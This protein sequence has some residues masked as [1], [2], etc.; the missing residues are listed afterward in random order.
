VSGRS[1]G[2]SPLREAEGA[3]LR[4]GGREIA[5]GGKGRRE[6]EDSTRA[7]GNERTHQ[8]HNYMMTSVNTK[9]L[10]LKLN[11]KLTC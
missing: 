10:T 9:V 2:R 6:G 4:E 3:E 11:I 7:E 5:S 1:G 8:Q